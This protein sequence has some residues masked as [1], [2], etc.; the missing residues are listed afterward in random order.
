MDIGSA[1]EWVSAAAA[2]AT[3]VIALKALLAW[4]DQVRGSSK[5]AAAAEI[6][7]AA[8][9]TRYH[10]YDARNAFYVTSEFPASYNQVS[11]ERSRQE[12]VD[13]WAHVYAARWN[14]LGP[15]ILRLATLR[16][17]AG[18]VLSEDCADAL[19]AMARKARELH[20]LF[21]ER[22]GQIRAGPAIVA[23]WPDQDWVQRVTNSVQVIRGDHTDPYSLEFEA[24]FAALKRLVDPFI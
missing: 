5:H 10:F 11:G 20:N 8:R 12:E 13:G 1:A 2:V 6:L 17:K 19:E 9:L 3:A 24:T 21:Q 23:Q 15:Q 14:L 16:A 4:R 7:E 22:I 18:A